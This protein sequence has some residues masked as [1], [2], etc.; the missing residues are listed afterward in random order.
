MGANHHVLIAG[1][2]KWHSTFHSNKSAIAGEMADSNLENL[3]E[4]FDKDEKEHLGELSS[5]SGAF[6]WHPA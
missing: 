1:G 3:D 2:N 4:A 6:E 5:M